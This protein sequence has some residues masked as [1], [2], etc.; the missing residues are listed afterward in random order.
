MAP[1]DQTSRR[2]VYVLRF[3][4]FDGL[5]VSVRR[6]SF[7]EVELLHHAVSILGETLDGNLS[8]V[9]DRIPALGSL[10]R[11]FAGSLMRW[12]LRDDGALVPTTE[13]GVLAQDYEFLWTVARAWYRQVVIGRDLEKSAAEPAPEQDNES[14]ELDDLLAEIPV[15]SL[16]EPAM[17]G[18]DQE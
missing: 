8:P 13:A 10:F 5:L 14:A 9:D 1:F 16:P 3:A 15:V 11:A 17:T 6:P 12:D 2:K 4:E 18:A 7:R